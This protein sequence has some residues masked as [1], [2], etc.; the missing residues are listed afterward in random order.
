MYNKGV[1][2]NVHLVIQLHLAKLAIRRL[3]LFKMFQVLS[4]KMFAQI[5]GSAE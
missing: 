3:F 4:A 1:P 5:A 2:L